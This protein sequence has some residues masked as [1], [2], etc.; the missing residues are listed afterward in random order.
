[1]PSNGLNYP[2]LIYILNEVG[3]QDE[4]VITK[5]VFESGLFPGFK[6]RGRYVTT[7]EKVIKPEDDSIRFGETKVVKVEND[8]KF[9]YKDNVID[10]LIFPTEKR[11]LF[12]LKNL[13]EHSIRIVWDEAVFVDTE[14]VTSKVIHEGIKY[15]ERNNSQTNSI[16]ISNATLEDIVVPNK[17]IRYSEILK[18]WVIDPIYPL[19]KDLLNLEI[20]LMLP[21]QIKN[22]INEYVFIFKIHWTYDHPE[23][24]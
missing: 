17:N 1:M 9:N 20:K 19:K 16:I 24:N 3:Q 15:N 14:G 6:D 4:I 21:I 13:S 12:S 22:V 5:E 7:L 2:S 18:E 11:F 23:L 8:T 10:L